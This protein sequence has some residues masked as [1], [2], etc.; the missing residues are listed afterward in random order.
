MPNIW[1]ITG[2]SRGLGRHVV[3][4]AL[5]AGDIV[6]A[7][8][9]RASDLD[10]IVARYGARVMPISL[11]VSDP[12]AVRAAIATCMSTFGRIDYVVNNAGYANLASVED[13]TADDFREQVETN[14]FGTVHV[15]KAVVPIMRRQGSGHIFQIASIGSRIASVELAPYQASKF[16]V[17]AFSLVLAQEVQPLGIQVTTLEPGGMRTEWAGASMRIP[18]ISAHYLETVAPFARMLPDYSGNEPTD[19]KKVAKLIVSLAGRRDAPVE[20]LV[21]DDAYAIAQA[22]A[23][24]VAASDKKWK[25]LTKSVAY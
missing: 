11:D 17:R 19:P 5:D 7:T 4:A 3:L 6:V 20:L 13:M 16:A 18:A 10:D 22:A 1:F 14:F 21:G 9:R 24:T 23:D 25:G 8:A 2:S 12:E 15:S